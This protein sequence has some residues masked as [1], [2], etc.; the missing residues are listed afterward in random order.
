MFYPCSYQSDNFLLDGEAIDFILTKKVENRKNLRL[1][2]R[3]VKQ[4]NSGMKSRSL[5]WCGT[6]AL[7][8][9][10]HPETVAHLMT[11]WGCSGWATPRPAAMIPLP[12]PQH[13]G[14]GKQLLEPFFSETIAGQLLSN[15]IIQECLPR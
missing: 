8:V 1:N 11:E 6:A 14:L 4:V 3:E 5:Q 10:I 12:A 15:A 13:G 7:G 2:V 9:V